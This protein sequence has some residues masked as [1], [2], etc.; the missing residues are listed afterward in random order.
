M[1]TPH[2]A[3]QRYEYGDRVKHWTIAISFFLAALSGLAFFHPSMFFLANFF[4]GGPWA[5]ILHPF[6]GLLMCVAFAVF[7]LKI[8]RD[9]MIDEKRS[10]EHTSEL[11][12]LRHLVCRL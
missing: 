6:L 4:G 5:R 1:R 10:E 9:N 12:S 3:I 8:W 7:A 2:D 11:Q